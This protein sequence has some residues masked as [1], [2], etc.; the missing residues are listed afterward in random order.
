LWDGIVGILGGFILAELLA[1]LVGLAMTNRLLQ[2]GVLEG[3]GRFVQFLSGSALLLLFVLCYEQGWWSGLTGTGML[4]L[5]WA[6]WVVRAEWQAMRDM[7]A[8]V[9]RATGYRLVPGW[10][11]DRP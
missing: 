6:A 4:L 8:L 10:M 2:R 3:G 7:L 1:F 11:V 9:D 5:L